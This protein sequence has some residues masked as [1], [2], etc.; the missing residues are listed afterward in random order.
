M[1]GITTAMS[2]RSA[3]GIPVGAV[4]LLVASLLLPLCAAEAA[5][6]DSCCACVP[7]VEATPETIPAL[8]CGFFQAGQ[9]PAATQECDAHD[10][11]QLY[12][13][14]CYSSASPS[15]CRAVLAEQS[16]ACPSP[17]GAP[18]AAPWALAALAALLAGGGAVILRRSV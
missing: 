7:E 6:V 17:A 2:R 1:T 3:V 13:L 12:V 14:S 11:H 4:A 18:A 5:Y 16:I 9:I 8:F 10:T 15:G